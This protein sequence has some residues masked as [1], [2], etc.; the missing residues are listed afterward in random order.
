M[1]KHDIVYITRRIACGV[2]LP[3]LAVLG[4]DLREDSQAEPSLSTANYLPSSPGVLVQQAL[5]STYC[6]KRL[7]NLRLRKANRLH[8]SDVLRSILGAALTVSQ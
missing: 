8:T 4:A 5:G 7:L 6:K 2:S 1:Q 3:G